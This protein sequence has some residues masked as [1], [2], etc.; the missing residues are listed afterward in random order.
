MK[1]PDHEKL[2]QELIN[3]YSAYMKDST[4]GEMKKAARKLHQEHGD[5]CKQADGYMAAA[6]SFLAN[7]GWEAIQPKPSRSEVEELVLSL[8]TRKT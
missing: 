1:V 5:S 4:D 6:V 3:V 2:R 7:I 8:A